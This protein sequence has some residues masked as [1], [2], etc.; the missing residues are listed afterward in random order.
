MGFFRQ[1]IVPLVTILIALFGLV[2]VTARSF[3][4]TDLAQPAPIET[5]YTQSTSSTSSNSL[6]SE[7]SPDL[8]N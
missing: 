7:T 3:I 5:I 8:P 2:A 4:S 1:Q 6:N